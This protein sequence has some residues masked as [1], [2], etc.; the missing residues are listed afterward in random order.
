MADVSKGD[1]GEVLDQADE[2][3]KQVCGIYTYTHTH[4]HT[5][6]RRA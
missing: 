4:T 6:T 3:S 5:L 2:L 1:L